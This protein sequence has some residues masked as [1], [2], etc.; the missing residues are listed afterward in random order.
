MFSPIL[1]FRRAFLA[2]CLIAGAGCF[3]FSAQGQ[4]QHLLSAPL[5][6]WGAPG[7]LQTPVAR[8][9]AAGEVFTGAARTGGGSSR[10][11][12]G[13]LF[14]GASPFSRL[15]I[16][17]RQT[18]YVNDFGLYEPGVDLA[19]LLA[20][21]GPWSPALAVGWRDALGTG[22][23][24]PGVGRFAGEYLVASKRFWSLD[25]SAGLGWGRLGGR[26]FA[27]NPLFWRGRGRP[28]TG[29]AA[30]GPRNW[31]SGDSVGL[32]G[33]VAWRPAAVEG[34]TVAAEISA[35]DWAAER[36]EGTARRKP[37]PVNA[38]ASW[39][40]SHPLLR[41]LEIAA[42]LENGRD[43][44]LRL[45]LRFG[46]NDLEIRRVSPPPA[47]PA[48]RSNVGR[49]LE[50]AL[51]AAPFRDALPLFAAAPPLFAASPSPL[52]AAS[53]FGVG[54][55]A[56]DGLIRRNDATAGPLARDVGRALR[57]QANVVPAGRPAEPGGDWLI[58]AARP[59]GLDGVAVAVPREA[60][61]RA[62]HGAGSA[63]EI[64]Q[65]ADI[66]PAS[67]LAPE[68]PVG[69]RAPWNW[70]W[71]AGLRL[72][73][74][75]SLFEHAAA[76][77]QRNYIDLGT[78][79]SPT[80]GVN[81]GAVVRSNIYS[82]LEGL[83]NAATPVAR[84]VRSDVADFAYG[85]TVERLHLSLRRSATPDWHVG[86]DVGWLE[87][88]FGGVGGEILHKPFGARW[89]VGAAAHRVW[90]RNPATVLRLDYGQGFTTALAS[91]YYEGEG[92]AW[93][94]A[95]D[96]GRYLGGDWGGGLTVVRRLAGEA[97]LTAFAVF[98]NGPDEDRQAWY[99][100]KGEYGLRLTVP[101]TGLGAATLR[102]LTGL[103]A[104]SAPLRLDAAARTLG[105]DAGQKLDR[106]SPMFD[107]LSG[108]GLGRLNGTWGRLLE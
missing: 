96:A 32:F 71:R 46:P 35:D 37:F 8:L 42:G 31:F 11:A 83:N 102:L 81:L 43:A 3:A 54:G 27:P 58:V 97:A 13:H 60:L 47:A 82:D 75:Q 93:T 79:W 85:P 66:G 9:P 70:G 48:P 49:D 12:V 73:S 77:P 55:P 64:L 23:H 41:P 105:R 33:G 2:A 52:F 78:G 108:A 40:P 6:T 22:P 18:S 104:P 91:F 28:A 7:L 94:A 106:P 103:D 20:E 69:D 36:E 62:A 25:F 16:G 57:A 34:L 72:A 67:R 84:P 74:E 30:R 95:L 5:S 101:L 21:E 19:A 92:A 68:T 38:G 61:L 86:A 26:S 88:M 63:E 99:G 56:P 87:E 29:P 107:A 89:G 17:L 80:P 4:E 76:A 45:T 59:D 98:T 90:K 14:V 15:W 53:P 51:P 50:K 65:V 10:L 44:M 39:R 100:G 24:L 1:L